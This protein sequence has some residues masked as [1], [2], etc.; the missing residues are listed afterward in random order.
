MSY[1]KEKEDMK[2]YLLNFYKFSPT[3]VE[4]SFNNG[5]GFVRSIVWSTFDR[6]EVREISTFEEYRL[7][8]TGEKNWIGERQFAMIYEFEDDYNSL[9]YNHEPND[10]CKFVFDSSTNNENMRFFGVTLI[11]FTP[12]TH[13]FFYDI[14]DN[15]C[16]PGK[17]IHSILRNGIEDVI[18]LNSIDR[19]KISYE[20]FGVLGGQ[21]VVVIWL[22][23]QFEDIAKVV[24]GIRKSKTQ[25]AHQVISNVYTIIGLKDVNN[26]KI[27]YNDVVGKLDIKLTKR[28]SFDAGVFE[29]DLNKVFC[30]GGQIKTYY[31]LFGEHDLMVSIDGNQ[32]VSTLYARN[33]VFN[34]KTPHFIQNFIQSKTEII[35]ENGYNEIQGSTFPIKS[36][37]NDNL[38]K[39]SQDLIN[40]Y[41]DKIDIIAQ[42]DCFAKAPYLQET[43]WLLYEDFLKNIMS[44]F[45]YPWTNDLDFQFENCLD[46]LLAVVGSEMDKDKKYKNIHELIS[47]MRQMMLH[48]AQANRIFFEIPNTH[49]KHTGA[50]SKILHTYY[51][52]VKEYLKLAYSI[53]KYD[54]QSP[55][56]PFISFDV[57][58]ITKSKFCD[59]V[60]GFENKI[61]RIELP[62]E[63]LVNIDKYIKL[64]AHEIYH[65]IAPPD[66]VERNMLVAT[67]SLAIIMGQ[68]TKLFF[69]ECIVPK[70][71]D[72]PIDLEDPNGKNVLVLENQLTYISKIVQKEVLNIPELNEKFMVWIDNYKANDEWEEFFDKF[73]NSVSNGLKG[74]SGLTE[75][76][77][78]SILKIKDLDN[79][80]E[81]YSK[82]ITKLGEYN[83]E[84]FKKWIC[85]SILL[86]E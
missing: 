8:K 32:L 44:T 61:I 40:K 65:Y 16:R 71:S 79:E 26:D 49:L 18:S 82:L 86:T 37:S 50:Y 20:V 43:L 10:E 22:A 5:E 84:K 42:S 77:W 45:S 73:S 24:E 59:N 80:N 63:A 38:H 46:Y 33:G 17:K 69:K 15:D 31:T 85:M 7:S 36:I 70:I 57:T 55:I 11:D 29:N 72:F 74:E 81:L 68:M 48:V 76:L 54:K 25:N 4:N 83:I 28:E 39:I 41:I 23:Y 14:G 27:T 62:Y 2:G 51:G 12:E 47:S 60:K 21:D 78:E 1:A 66:R 67:M 34:S 53:P 6:L 58:P 75:L 35:I 30:N 56:V 3:N 13:Q 19:E 9:Y 52:V 64:L